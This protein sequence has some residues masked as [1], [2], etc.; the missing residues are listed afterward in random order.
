[1]GEGVREEAELSEGEGVMD[2]SADPATDMLSASLLLPSTFFDP[3]PVTCLRLD[4]VATELP[5]A[6]PARAAAVE[7]AAA[8]LRLDG[9]R[10]AVEG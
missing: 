1:M 5:S 7:A 3:R 4:R 8:A 2:P 9:G 10:V 6:L